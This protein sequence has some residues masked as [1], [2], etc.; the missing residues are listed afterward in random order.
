MARF[1]PDGQRL[2]VG[3]R[4][5]GVLACWDVRQTAKPVIE[6]RRTVRTNQR[7]QFDVSSCGRW[8]VSG[9]TEGIVRAWDLSQ[10]DAETIPEYQVIIIVFIS[11]IFNIGFPPFLTVSATQRLL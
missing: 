11:F 9:D 5:D 6:L 1:S 2:F 10:G 3:A 8:L 7:I 4:K